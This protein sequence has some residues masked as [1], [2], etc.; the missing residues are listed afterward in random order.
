MTE[1]TR[2]LNQID[3]GNLSAAAQLLPLVAAANNILARRLLM[4]TKPPNW[5]V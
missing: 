5:I 3:N 1:V 2:I 4:Y